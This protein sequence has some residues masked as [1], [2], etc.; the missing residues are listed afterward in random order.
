[1]IVLVKAGYCTPVF[2]SQLGRIFDAGLALLRGIDKKHT[3][4][5][6]L[7]QPAKI[8]FFIAIN[9][10]H[11]LAQVEQLQGGGDTGNAPANNDDFGLIIFHRHKSILR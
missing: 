11:L 10:Q 5:A 3:A 7:G 9:Q 8:G 4:K 2:V 6:L 1:M